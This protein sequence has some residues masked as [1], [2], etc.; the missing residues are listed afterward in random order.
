MVVN[1][2][3]YGEITRLFLLT[4]TYKEKK[5]SKTGTPDGDTEARQDTTYNPDAGQSSSGNGS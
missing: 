1:L 4:H 5:K 2:R 3:D